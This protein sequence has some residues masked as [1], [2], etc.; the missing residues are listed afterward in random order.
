M[1]QIYKWTALTMVPY[2]LHFSEN[3]PNVWDG[4]PSCDTISSS[5]SQASPCMFFSHDPSI[6]IP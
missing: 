3:S 5:Q 1:P 4:I 6:H 2:V